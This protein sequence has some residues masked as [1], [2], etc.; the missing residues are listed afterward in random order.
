[1]TKIRPLDATI[2]FASLGV[3][4]MLRSLKK[5]KCVD[6]NEMSDGVGNNSRRSEWLKQ[7]IWILTVSRNTIVLLLTSV[8]A[9]YLIEVRG[10]KDI[11]EVTGNVKGGI[12][13]WQLPWKFTSG[14]TSFDPYDNTH[15]LNVASNSSPHMKAFKR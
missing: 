15:K 4:L 3:I 5:L 9:Y 12:P 1:M 7:A 11:I 2:G 10:M 14:N 8:L 6:N 13:S